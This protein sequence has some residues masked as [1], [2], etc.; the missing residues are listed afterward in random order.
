MLVVAATEA[1]HRGREHPAAGG[2]ER[3]GG[4]REDEGHRGEEGLAPSYSEDNA[5]TSASTRS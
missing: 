3:R 2:E 4:G 1:R 5:S